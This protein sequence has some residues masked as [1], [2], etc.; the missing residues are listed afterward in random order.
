MLS[1]TSVLPYFVLMLLFWFEA[2]LVQ[3][4]VP[5]FR[6]AVQQEAGDRS[7]NV[8]LDG[9]RAVLALGVFFT[10]SLTFHYWMVNRHWGLP[11][12][13]FYSQLSIAPVAC[14]FVI[15]GFLFWTKAQ[16]KGLGPLNIYFFHRIRRLYPAYLFACFLILAV[17]FWLGGPPNHPW[18]L[19]L[20]RCLMPFLT[21]SLVDGAPINHLENVGIINAGVTWTLRVE[22][23]FYLM[24]PIVALFARK[25]WSQIL[26]LG[27]SVI[28]YF[29]LP[30][31]RVRFHDPLGLGT[32]MYF[33]HFLLSYFSVGMLLAFM[34]LRYR[35]ESFVN[36]WIAACIAICFLLLLFFAP[37]KEGL[38]EGALV[39]FPMLV[40][41]YGNSFFGILSSRPLVLLG[42]ASY[43]IYLLH[44]IV[45]YVSNQLIYRSSLAA[46]I[47]PWSF[48]TIHAIL[49]TII[50]ALATFS[51]RYFEAPFMQGYGM[52]NR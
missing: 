27:V 22:W 46:R 18:G 10:H 42:Q 17:I 29:G 4:Y 34:R 1:F 21:F 3:E 44:G 13:Q 49:G 5:F 7:H 45:L 30:A 28:L 2:W 8:P 38:L 47:T 26:L 15:T 14:F 33:N 43:S 52:K 35:W 9:L 48:W 19:R 39:A 6:R 41:V 50:V 25:T 11:P 37:P 12:S 36:G 24:L 20:L 16:K 32:L 51:Y 31:F 40:V 23:M